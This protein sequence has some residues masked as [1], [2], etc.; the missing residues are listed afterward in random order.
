MPIIKYKSITQSQLSQ[1]EEKDLHPVIP[2]KKQWDIVE[3]YYL[4]IAEYK[5]NNHLSLSLS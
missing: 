4:P 5:R 3:Y 1:K 2:K